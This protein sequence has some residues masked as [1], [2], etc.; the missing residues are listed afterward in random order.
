MLYPSLIFY[1]DTSGG[2]EPIQIIDNLDQ[3]RT[4]KPDAM[5]WPF[6]ISSMRLGLL[7][8]TLKCD[9]M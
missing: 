4:Y 8:L 6:L 1:T 2:P 3:A 9:D 7:Y 5:W